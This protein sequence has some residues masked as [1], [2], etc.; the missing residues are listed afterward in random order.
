MDGHTHTRKKNVTPKDSLR[1]NARSLKNLQKRK[2][3]TDLGPIDKESSRRNS[4]KKI[5]QAMSSVFQWATTPLIKRKSSYTNSLNRNE[6]S[7]YL[8]FL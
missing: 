6:S 7:L 2:R 4:I 5:N 8:N 1:I 3:I